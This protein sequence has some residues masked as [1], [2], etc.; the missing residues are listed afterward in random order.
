MI[1]YDE[2]TAS[3]DPIK[4]KEIYS[5]LKKIDSNTSVYI[6]HRMAS[7]KDVNRIIVLE[8]G[9]VIEEG[10]HLELMNKKGL[11]YELF[12]SQAEWYL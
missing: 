8:K 10:N 12:S 3:I 9:E 11:Y 5:I 4:E 6:T 1:I 7:I 2:P